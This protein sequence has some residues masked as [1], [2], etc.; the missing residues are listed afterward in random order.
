M[1]LK[2]N[3]ADVVSIPIDYNNS[4]GRCCRYEVIKELPMPK[5]FNNPEDS[6]A[7][8]WYGDDEEYTSEDE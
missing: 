8:V 3:P 2:I 6:W 5:D 4:K 7:A 1:L